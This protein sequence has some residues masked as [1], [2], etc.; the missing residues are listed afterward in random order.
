MLISII[1]PAFNEIDNLKSTLEAIYLSAEA[2]SDIGWRYECIVCD[3][4]STDGTADLAKSLG[5]EVVY[6]PVNQI[7]RARNK[8]A[9][10]SNGD[11]LI[12][13][14][15]DSRPTKELFNCVVKEIQSEKTVGGGSL[16]Y[17]ESNRFWFKFCVASWNIVSVVFNWAAGSFIY[18]KNDAFKSVHGFSEDLFAAEEID[19]SKK[20]KRWAGKR[21]LKFR[22]IREAPLW[23]SA[24]KEDLYTTGEWLRFFRKAFFS[25]MK[26]LKQRQ[27]CQPWYDG[28]R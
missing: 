2:F 4:N 15:A 3:N 23:S 14:D 7:S 5:A 19:F 8:G 9:E 16:V 27:A 22:I 18:C 11:W 10:A 17:M 25:P 6:E 20:L 21:N 12:F 24:R 1:I 13:I 28:R 26:T